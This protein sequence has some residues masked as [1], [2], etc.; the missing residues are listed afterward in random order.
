[1]ARPDTDRLV[2]AARRGDEASFAAL[3]ERYR[4]ELLVHCYRMVGSFTEAEDL[5]QET[6]LRGWRGLGMF[7]GRSTFRA[8]MYRIATN[9]CLDFL[10]RR[11]P[12]LLP[13]DVVPPT[14]PGD[15]AGAAEYPS[16]EPF[17]DRLLE[18]Q[19]EDD[20]DAVV[21]ARE[22]IELAFLAA[23]QH[24]P[25]RQRAVL[26]LRDVLGWPAKDAGAVLDMSEVAVKSALQRAR[27][28][29][30]E[31]VPPG[32]EDWRAGP[33][34]TE[35]E[36]SLLERYIDAHERDDPEALAA[37][38][39][40]DIRVSYPPHPLWRDSR[41]SFITSSAADAPAGEYRFLTTRANRQPAVAIYL[42]EPGQA[43]FRPVALEL[44]RIEGDRIAE[45]VDFD[46]PH[47]VREFGLP[48]E[49]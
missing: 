4:R 7:E 5:V 42:R 28:T 9:A 15:V 41:D 46:L 1:M 38:L 44:L 43:T 34:T 22:T 36:R 20:P 12:R 17:P 39:R 2:A 13:Y 25:V 33:P 19:A 32:R 3:V 31:H 18:S 26:I 40:E 27:A 29:L 21:V 16:I 35:V 48:G 11:Q 47:L 6:F 45:I 8:W 30:K 23:I 37:V 14:A 24:L 10:D 49:L